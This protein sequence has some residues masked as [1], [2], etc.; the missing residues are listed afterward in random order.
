MNYQHVMENRERGFNTTIDGMKYENEKI[1]REHEVD[2]GRI[3]RNDQQFH[4]IQKDFDAQCLKNLEILARHDEEYHQKMCAL[5]ERTLVCENKL[6]IL[7]KDHFDL[8]RLIVEANN[9]LEKL[10]IDLEGQAG[11]TKELQKVKLNEKDFKVYTGK[12]GIQM[13]Q[14]KKRIGIDETEVQ[15]FANY[16]TRYMPIHLINSLAEVLSDTLD[17]R[18][19]VKLEK[20]VLSKYE[21]YKN[22]KENKL[23]L[24][25]DILD[26]KK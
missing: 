16:I 14:M 24:L 3:T 21:L 11:V 6:E 15:E 12:N 1:K 13:E 2:Q 18:G 5:S 4:R 8:N 9:R 19:I 23:R 25:Y 17:H 10:Q 20:V 7:E 26:Q 22:M